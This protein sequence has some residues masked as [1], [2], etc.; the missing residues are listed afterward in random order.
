VEQ[1]RL[2]QGREVARSLAKALES[3]RLAR[4]PSGADPCVEFGRAVRTFVRHHGRFQLRVAG[5]GLRLGSEPLTDDQGRFAGLARRLVL[6]GVS[7]LTVEPGVSDDEVTPL[8]EALGTEDAAT[9]VLDA[10]LEHVAVTSLEFVPRLERPDA[11]SA[12]ARNVLQELHKVSDALAKELEAKGTLGAAQ[13][14]YELTDSGGEFARLEKV[15]PPPAEGERAPPAPPTE[16]V[17]AL[18]ARVLEATQP[19]AVLFSLVDTVL[20]G[21]ALAPKTIG[22]EHA[23]WFLELAPD[24][25]LREENL[26][27]VAAVLGRFAREQKV[28]KG[29]AADAVRGIVQAFT[30]ERGLE[31]LVAVGAGGSDPAAFCAILGV[32]GEHAVPTALAAWQRTRSKELR[33]ALGTFLAERIA[34]APAAL[35]PLLQPNASVEVAKFA[36][37]LVSRG[38][39]GALADAL[40][41]LGKAHPEPAVAQYA[42]FLWRTHT[43]RG[44]LAALLESLEKNDVQDRIT[45]VNLLAK[46]KDQLALPSLIKVVQDPSFLDRTPEEMDAFLAAIAAIGGPETIKFFEEQAGRSSGLFRL[47]AGNDLRGKARGISE[48]LRREG[49]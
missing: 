26:A 25:A 3:A 18:R 19:D 46:A 32:V 40:Y 35:E 49:P 27:L 34:R 11:Y 17:L 12:E 13:A 37:F 21:F 4:T 15:P 9:S 7:E 16:A 22:P 41:E 5:R 47:R 29:P 24:H 48:R 38:L 8:L 36:L 44:R 14:V 31:R 2:W 45:V 20:E 28:L 10:G 42:T 39:E 6:G 43:A 23:K 30:S 1:D 33:D